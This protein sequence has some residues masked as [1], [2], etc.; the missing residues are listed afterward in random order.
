MHDEKAYISVVIPLLNEADVVEN[1]LAEVTR[2]LDGIDRRHEV[3]VVDD[4]STDD[5]FALV[6][7][8]HRSDSRIKGIRLSR[9]FGKES[10]MLAGLSKARGLA[11][12]TMDATCNTRRH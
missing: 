10:A 6:E 11:V 1:T 9:R 3:I 8:A 7:N 4:G 5:T 12:V 2:V